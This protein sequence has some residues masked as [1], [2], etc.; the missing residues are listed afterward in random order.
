MFSVYQRQQS[1][2]HLIYRRVVVRHKAAHLF[3]FCLAEN[4]VKLLAVPSIVVS[5]FCIDRL[6]LC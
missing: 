4:V 2:Q 6:C 5:L 1:R 3:L